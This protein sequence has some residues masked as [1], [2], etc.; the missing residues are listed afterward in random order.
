LTQILRKAIWPSAIAV[1]FLVFL[2]AVG[3]VR[4]A[5][6][7]VTDVFVVDPEDAIDGCAVPSVTFVSLPAAASL[8]DDA[9]AEDFDIYYAGTTSSSGDLSD[10]DDDE[11]SIVQVDEDG[12]FWFCIIVDELDEDVSVDSNEVGVFES[13]LCDVFDDLD[14]SCAS[15]DG[16]GDDDFEVDVE[17]DGDGGFTVDLSLG[18]LVE[19]SCDG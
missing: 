7:E 10:E 17:D 8:S 6:A 2:G 5:Y 9:A 1:A 15:V 11:Y 16:V 3:G 13:V 14:D 4:P 19:F 12:S 18:I